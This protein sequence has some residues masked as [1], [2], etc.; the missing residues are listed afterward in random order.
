MKTKKIIALILAVLMSLAVLA[1]CASGNEGDDTGSVDTGSQQTDIESKEFKKADYEGEDFSFATF[2][3]AVNGETEYYC[4]EWIDCDDIVG[5]ATS[6]AVYKRNMLCEQ[7]YNVVIKNE[8]KGESY[9]EY[10][11]LVLKGDQS[12]DVVYSWASRL[13][14]GVVDGQFYDFY[15]LADKDYIDLEEDYWNPTVNKSLEVG[16]RL[17]IATNDITMSSLSWT[18]CLFF[19]PEIVEIY[20]LENPHDLVD[21]GEWTI[22]KYLEMVGAVHGELDGNPD[23]TIEDCYGM[24]DFGS[25]GLLYGCGVTLVNDDDLSVNIGSERVIGLISKIRKV[26]DNKAYVFTF[27]DDYPDKAQS[28]NMWEYVRQYFAN[29][30]CLFLGGSPELTRE[31]RDMETGY[32]IVPMPKFDKNQKEYVAGIDQNAGAFA[33]P[34][35]IRRD[36]NGADYERTGTILEYLAYKSSEDVESSVLNAYY[37]TTIKKQRQ[38]I[39]KNMDMLDNFIKGKGHYEWADVFAVG[40]VGDDDSKTISGVLGAMAAKASGQVKVYRASASRLQKAVN[41]KWDAIANIKNDE[42][43]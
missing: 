3:S 9:T 41:D 12:W 17:F 30:H 25:N 8:I 2:T 21:K 5:I 33:L 6:D 24:I 43:K 42:A 32:G 11:D 14:D 38:T 27:N 1:S 34:I 7:K 31:F 16:D 40:K 36:V 23:F 18:G 13:A 4:G 29:G 15:N 10:Q 28:S 35:L 20:N 19:N 26:F 37:E 22:D 39:D